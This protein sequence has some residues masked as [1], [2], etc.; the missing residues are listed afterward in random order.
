MKNI[1]K[2]AILILLTV[3]CSGSQEKNKELITANPFLIGAWTGKG[4]FFDMSLNSSVGSVSFEITI[5]LENIVS[6]KVG[7]A[8]LTKTSIRKTDYG[9]EIRGILD[10][11]IKKDHDLERDH[12]IILLVMPEDKGDCVNFSDA[13]FHLK[14][15]YFFD[16]AMRVGGVALR[17]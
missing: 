10:A 16:F 17:K 5:D 8:S 2:L 4:N 15:N 6:G 13:N 12:L 7:D 1:S 3:S 14:N 9:F 11:K